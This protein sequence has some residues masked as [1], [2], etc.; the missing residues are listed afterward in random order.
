[1]KGFLRLRLQQSELLVGLPL[2]HL[3]YANDSKNFA[4]TRVVEE[5]H[6][7]SHDWTRTEPMARRFL[8]LVN[9]MLVSGILRNYERDKRLLL[10]RNP[11]TSHM[12][13]T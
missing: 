8:K 7:S 2:L 1:M 11:R 3:F 4:F 5:I 10:S 12:P 9:E 13:R 6:A